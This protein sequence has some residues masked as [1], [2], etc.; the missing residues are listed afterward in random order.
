MNRQ[1]PPDGIEW[2]RVRNPDGSVRPGYTWNPVAGCFHGCA[3]EMPDLVMAECYAK[4]VAEGLANAAYPEG[5][6]HHYWHPDRLDEPLSLKQPAGIFCD[7]M[8]DLFGHWVPEDQVRQVLDVMRRTPRHVY[9]SLTKHAPGLLK[10]AGDL[11][12][13]LWAGVSLP[14]THMWGRRT[15]EGQ[16]YRLLGRALAVLARLEGRIRWLSLEPLCFDTAPLLAQAFAQHGPMLEWLVVGAASAGRRKY[17]PE[18]AWVESLHAFAHEHDIPVFHKGNLLWPRRRADFP[19]WQASGQKRVTIYTTRVDKWCARECA[20]QGI[21][22]LDVTR[23]SGDQYTPEA[24]RAV[25]GS[26]GHFAP[27][28]GLPHHPV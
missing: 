24:L 3:W 4:G 15:S 28:D 1:N 19:T 11:P 5:F 2:T 10:Y 6:D 9:L 20:A 16:Q 14:P 21:V 7:S 12:D 23:K 17:Q 22:Y 25:G 18:R 27:T 13:N 8:S 26:G